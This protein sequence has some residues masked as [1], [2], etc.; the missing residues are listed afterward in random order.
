MLILKPLPCQAVDPV[1]L[2][3]PSSCYPA[4]AAAPP[5]SLTPACPQL[6]TWPFHSQELARSVAWCAWH[7]HEIHA[8]IACT[9]QLNLYGLGG[10]MKGGWH[11]IPG[12]PSTQDL[13]SPKWPSKFAYVC[14]MN[15]RLT[16][17]CTIAASQP[18]NDPTL[19]V[20]IHKE[21]EPGQS[22]CL[23]G[24]LMHLQAGPVLCG[25]KK[26]ETSQPEGA[27]DEGAQQGE[28]QEVHEGA[29]QA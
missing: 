27:Q 14:K 16:R 29:G 12:V 21:G 4:Q 19:S 5:S 11:P 17:I 3:A 10:G 24:I 8:H 7:L 6:Y 13:P 1:L 15:A 28:G 25:K 26:P 9:E 22:T 2:A 18:T 20:S 23:H